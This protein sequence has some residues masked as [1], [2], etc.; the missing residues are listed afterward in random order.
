VVLQLS[1]LESC[2]V[3]CLLP[4][5]LVTTFVIGSLEPQRLVSSC[6]FFVCILCKSWFPAHL[7]FWLQIQG[8]WVSMGVYS[9]GS[10]NVPAGLIYSFPVT[11]RN[12]EWKIVQGN[13][14]HALIIHSV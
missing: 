2:Q 7:P 10:Y 13:V 3:H 14:Q 12:G 8:T 6:L 11:C 4:A 5:L 1:K 9:D